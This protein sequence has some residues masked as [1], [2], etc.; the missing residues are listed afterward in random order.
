MRGG[1]RMLRREPDAGILGSKIF[2]DKAHLLEPE[3]AVSGLDTL[4]AKVDRGSCKLGKRRGPSQC[5]FL[6]SVFSSGVVPR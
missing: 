1:S 6:V 4:G 3:C 2:E 5:A